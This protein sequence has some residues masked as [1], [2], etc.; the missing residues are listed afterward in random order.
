MLKELEKLIKER[1][2]KRVIHFRPLEHQ[3][4]SF[5]DNFVSTQENHI[6]PDNKNALKNVKIQDIRVYSTPVTPAVPIRPRGEGPSVR[7]TS[8][9]AKPPI[10]V[11]TP[12]SF[13]EKD[14]KTS[15]V[16]SSTLP[17]TT[18]SKALIIKNELDVSPK[19]QF[20]FKPITTKSWCINT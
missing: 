1:A 18:S 17:P 6:F 7:F 16:V 2:E 3:S 20:G 9:T 13:R 15:T 19:L 14:V 12:F 10:S 5:K 8:T 4:I 11:T